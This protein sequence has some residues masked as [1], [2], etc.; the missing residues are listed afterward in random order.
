[1]TPNAITTYFNANPSPVKDGNHLA[2]PLSTSK[3]KGFRLIPNV[4]TSTRQD[5][6]P[7]LTTLTYRQPNSPCTQC[8]T[9]S[10]TWIKSPTDGITSYDAT[11]RTIVAN[12]NRIICTMLTQRL[13]LTPMP[14]IEN[15]L[16][17]S[18]WNATTF[19]CS[20]MGRDRA[21]SSST[22]APAVSNT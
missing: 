22:N 15:Y 11:Y 9:T 7:T 3:L 18:W 20:V 17:V 4:C 6:G 5:S 13:S 14:G 2:S 12:S 1:M 21:L 10:L 19:G 16:V 8:K